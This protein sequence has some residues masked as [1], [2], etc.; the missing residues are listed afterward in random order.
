MSTTHEQSRFNKG[1][2]LHFDFGKTD[3]AIAV[4]QKVLAMNP[5]YQT[6]N[7]TPLQELINQ[8][9]EEQKNNNG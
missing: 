6:G 1:I 4:W 9:T 2:V 3:E 8:L 5:N 7:G